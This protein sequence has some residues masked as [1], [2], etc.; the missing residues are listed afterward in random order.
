MTTSDT[1][2]TDRRDFALLFITR[3]VRLFAASPFLGELKAQLGDATQRILAGTHD[4]DLTAVGPAEI[5]RRIA[6]ALKQPQ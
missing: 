6:Q 5:G 3:S 4:L 2:T 1:L